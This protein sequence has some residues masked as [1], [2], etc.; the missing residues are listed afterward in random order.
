MPREKSVELS[1]LRVGIAG[2]GMVGKVRHEVADAHPRLEVVAVCDQ[3]FAEPA[4]LET[5]LRCWPSY[6]QLLEEELDVLFVSLPN[7]QIGRAHV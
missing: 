4:T 2:H 3:T 1:P 7:Y 6:T 5:G